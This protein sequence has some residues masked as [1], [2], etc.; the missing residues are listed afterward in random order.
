MWFTD[1]LSA[2]SILVVLPRFF[3]QSLCSN[4]ISLTEY[5]ALYSFYNSTNGNDWNWKSVVEYGLKW[6][7]DPDVEGGNASLSKPCTE[8]WQGLSCDFVIDS[9]NTCYVKS[10]A[11]VDYNLTGSLPSVINGLSKLTSLSLSFNYLSSTIPRQLWD[12][13]H[14]QDLSLNNNMISGPIRAEIGNVSTLLLLNLEF[15]FFTSTV[16]AQLSNS[17]SLQHLYLSTNSFSGYLS[18]SLGHLPKLEYMTLNQNQLS[19]SI[20]IS[21]QNL[22]SLT[23]SPVFFSSV[24]YLLAM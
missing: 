5:N 14:L 2:L 20:P 18:E 7:F 23:V 6:N 11:L 9:S 16:P 21:F 1:V 19:G 15:N 8:H 13:G 4:A 3:S 22:S 17:Q 10:L 24:F 12:L